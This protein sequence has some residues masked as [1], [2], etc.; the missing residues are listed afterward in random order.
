MSLKSLV[1][2]S[3]APR[4]QANSQRQAK[5]A[6]ADQDKWLRKL[7]LTAKNTR[8]GKDHHFQDIK[9]Y[10]DFVNR[11]P[12]SDYEDLR[13]YV[14]QVV[15]GKPNILWPG[16]PKY[17]GKTSGTTSGIKY[18]PITKDSI[19]HHIN[20][21]RNAILHYVADTRSH[22]FDGQMIFISGSPKLTQK[23][24]IPTGRLSGIVNHEIPSWAK[25]NQLPSW[26]TN[27][28]E[29]WETKLDSIVEETYNKDLRL[30]SGIPPWVQMYYERLLSKTGKSTI[31]EVFPNLEL[32][33]YGGVNFAPYKA[34]IDKL[35]GAN[36]TTLE[37]YPASEGFIAYQDD[38]KEEA[39][40]LNTNAGMFF[41]FIPL[42][43]VNQPNPTRLSLREV[44]LDKDYAIIL[45]TNAGLWA[46]MLGDTVR[47]QS[48]R[49]YRIIVSG[50]VKHFISAFGEHVISKEVEEAMRQAA[51]KHKLVIH[52]F[53]VAPQVN[54]QD[55]ALPHHEWYIDMDET[56]I[57]LSEIAATLDQLI[58]K[59]NIYYKDLIDGQ[60]LQPL[61]ITKV[62]PGA[63]REYM[64]SIGKLGG[65]NKVP[66]LKNDR[67]LVEEL[68]LL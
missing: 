28:I 11:V 68:R 60:I 48:L 53:T 65:Q 67:S 20:S 58:T 16:L 36:I 12:I 3:I 32:F 2:K 29:D 33:I 10:A 30:I 55:D 62:A 17:F 8:F 4:I 51:D 24:G 6:L 46:Y 25:G 27:C 15:D 61:K 37:T 59:Q 54:P 49:P 50:R 22:L 40:L 7:I 23:S 47:F 42:Q 43:E 44:E 5:N 13:K 57:P 63:F 9:T 41:E 31:K 34:S 39:L 14:D 18:I 38:Y 35:H 56:H 66:R 26:Q 21:A 19:T 52:E 1:I 64:E 45:S